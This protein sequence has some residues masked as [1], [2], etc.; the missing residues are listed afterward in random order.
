MFPALSVVLQV[1]VRVPTCV[2]SGV[3]H[4]AEPDRTTEVASEAFG[5]TVSELPSSTG[6]RLDKVGARLGFVVSSLT[7]MVPLPVPPALVAVQVRV[8]PLVSVF[9][10]V[11]SQPLWLVRSIRI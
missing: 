6:C 3:P 1:T 7:V 8:V 10:T 5:L 2:V 4:E 9:S 11:P